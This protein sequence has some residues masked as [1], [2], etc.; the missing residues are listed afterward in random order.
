MTELCRYLRCSSVSLQFPEGRLHWAL[1]ETTISS[2]R[3]FSREP[4]CKSRA[5][6]AAWADSL[7]DKNAPI[8]GAVRGKQRQSNRCAHQFNASAAPFL[9]NG[10]IPSDR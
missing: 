9:C 3:P 8:Q 4:R 1:P 10:E 5:S 6:F 7:N 2:F